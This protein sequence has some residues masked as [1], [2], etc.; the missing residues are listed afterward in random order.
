MSNS[1]VLQVYFS[2]FPASRAICKLKSERSETT[3]I[4]TRLHTHTVLS[5]VLYACRTCKDGRPSEVRG[6]SVRASAVRSDRAARGPRRVRSVR[7]AT[8]QHRTHSHDTAWLPSQDSLPVC[9]P[10]APPGTRC[11]SWIMVLVRYRTQLFA[12]GFLLSVSPFGVQ[13]SAESGRGKLCE[14]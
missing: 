9:P 3:V 6:A 11:I 7:C 10:R 14:V 1:G 13:A 2:V 5:S 12:R 8:V 4:E